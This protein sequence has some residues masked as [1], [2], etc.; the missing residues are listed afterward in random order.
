MKLLLYL[1]L[2]IFLLTVF[3]QDLSPYRVLR[4]PYFE[5]QRLRTTS[6]LEEVEKLI[7]RTAA[8]VVELDSNPTLRKYTL[9]V[10]LI[11]PKKVPLQFEGKA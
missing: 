11:V 10:P 4:T 1:R 6:R 3:L 9:L 8:A 2:A 7:L 5:Y